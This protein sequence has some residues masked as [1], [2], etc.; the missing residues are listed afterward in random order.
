MII[1]VQPPQRLLINPIM[2]EYLHFPA[3]K[4]RFIL[5]LKADDSGH[6]LFPLQ[7]HMTLQVFAVRSNEGGKLS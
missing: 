4:L 2:A 5:V 6:L 7:R 3:H 1:A